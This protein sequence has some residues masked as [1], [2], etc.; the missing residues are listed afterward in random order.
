M[1]IIKEEAEYC[2]SGGR[3]VW[4]TAEIIQNRVQTYMNEHSD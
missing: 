4:K 3:D 1:E 2:F